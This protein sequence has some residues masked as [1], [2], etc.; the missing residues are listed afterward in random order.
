MD[1]L[2]TPA[3]VAVNLHVGQMVNGQMVTSVNADRLQVE[4][5]L[6]P[7]GIEILSKKKLIKTIPYSNVQGI[8]YKS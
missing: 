2:D 5:F 7:V 4:M 6:G 3:V 1:I 8:D